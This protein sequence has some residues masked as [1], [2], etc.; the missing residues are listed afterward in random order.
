METI[1]R[2]ALAL[3][4]AERARLVDA[5]WESLGDTTCSLLSKE[6]E[7][8]IERRRQEVASGRVKPVAGEEVSRKARELA[9]K[10]S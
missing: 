6:W 4:A 8:E 2:E 9:R 7:A 10:R 5:L 1:E 3:P